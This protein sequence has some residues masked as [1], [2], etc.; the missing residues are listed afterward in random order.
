MHLREL[1]SLA[2]KYLIY[3]PSLFN[4]RVTT[5]DPNTISLADSDEQVLPTFVSLAHQHG[6][7]ASL[8]IG[9][10]TGSIYYSSNVATE[11]NRT[12]LVNAVLGL[13]KKY[14][15]DGIDFEFV[16]ILMI[17]V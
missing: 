5:P 13:V 11:A 2:R 6:V 1:F 10:W 16:L 9:G 8:S 17:Q 14:D 15:L 3:L 7:K 4:D 12:A